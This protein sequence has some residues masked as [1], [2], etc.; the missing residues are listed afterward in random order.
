MGVVAQGER[1]VIIR[2][3]LKLRMTLMALLGWFPVT[4]LLG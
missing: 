4:G 3:R 1:S 2:A